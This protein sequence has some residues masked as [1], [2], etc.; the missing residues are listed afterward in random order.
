MRSLVIGLMAALSMSA[1]TNKISA[2][3]DFIGRNASV[4]KSDLMTPEVL[5]A[6]GRVGGVS[7]STDGKKL[8][9]NVTYYSVEQNKSNSELFVLNPEDGTPVQ[10]THDNKYQ[11]MAHW[12]ATDKI[13]YLSTESGS[14]QVWEMQI[15]NNL[16]ALKLL[17]VQSLL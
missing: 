7:A 14:A 17:F 1:M 3:D 8:V 9:Y 5:W 6:L 2:N 4:I 15:K 13:A 11:G 10:L 12:I 16:K